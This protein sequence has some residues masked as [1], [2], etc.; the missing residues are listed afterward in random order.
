MIKINFSHNLIWIEWRAQYQSKQSRPCLESP[1]MPTSNSEGT[2]FTNIGMMLIVQIGWKKNGMDYQR[3]WRRSWTRPTSSSLRTI[4]R[5]LRNG[6]RSTIWTIRISRSSRKGRNR[7]RRLRSLRGSPAR[8]MGR[9]R[10]RMRRMLPSP[11]KRQKRETRERTPR[12]RKRTRA[13]K[14]TKERTTRKTP[15]AKERTDQIKF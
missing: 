2:S 12:L 9:R 8:V 14:K 3:L 11:R 5:I 15:R 6:R 7:R 10:L 4:R 13:P 1:W